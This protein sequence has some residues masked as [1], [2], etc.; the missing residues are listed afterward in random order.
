MVEKDMQ[1]LFGR[2]LQENKPERP[3]AFE[4]KIVKGTSVPFGRVKDHQVT[5]LGAV[6]NGGLYHKIQ[7]S[8][9]SWGMG[10]GMR[11]TK[12]KPFDCMHLVGDAYVVLWFY[13]PR[14]KKQAMWIDVDTWVN[15][16]D[17]SERKSLTKSRAEEI[18]SFI[19]EL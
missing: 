6:K 13:E 10:S 5:A 4:L 11:F 16:R 17:T 12:P 2:W 3:S 15:E 14:K 19:H 7:D 18:S 9:V 1:V 8:P